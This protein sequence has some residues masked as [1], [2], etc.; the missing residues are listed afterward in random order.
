MKA[1]P[2]AEA[3]RTVEGLEEQSTRVTVGRP[4][5]KGTRVG[6]RRSVLAEAEMTGRNGDAAGEGEVLSGVV[7]GWGGSDTFH[8]Q[9]EAVGR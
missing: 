2:A 3:R 1:H 6:Q 5:L 9:R 4:D 7:S 8:R